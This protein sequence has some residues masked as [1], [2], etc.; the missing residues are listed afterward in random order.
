MSLRNLIAG[1]GELAVRDAS[2]A[3]AL[4]LLRSADT[5]IKVLDDV[6]SG[7]RVVKSDAGFLLVEGESVE[8]V[9]NLLRSADLEGL[10]RLT[11]RDIPILESDVIEFRRLVP[12]NPE[13]ALNVLS[14]EII[15]SKT[16]RSYLDVSPENIESLPTNAITDLNKV[17]NNLLKRFVLNAKIPL[18]VGSVIVG[19]DWIIKA[20]RARKGCYMFTTINGKTTSCKIMAYSCMSDVIPNDECRG[21]TNYYNTTLTLMA[22]VDLEDS[23]GRKT[24]LAAAVGIPV[25]Q[26]R[27]NLSK[28]VRENFTE[29]TNYIKNMPNRPTLDVCGLKNSQI[30]QGVVPPCRLC[31]PSALPTST[32]YISSAQFGENIT[33]KCINSVSIL[34]VITDAIVST[35]INLWDG[36]GTPIFN[37]LKKIGI[38][39]GSILLVVF[40]FAFA[41]RMF[42]NKSY[43]YKKI[44]NN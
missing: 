32:Q 29:A 39:L 42:M 20:S 10:V 19:A 17:S 12:D 14:R 7:L 41:V 30:E 3:E 2:E 33:F 37:T 40:I 8:S 15:E 22:I 43:S 1:L 13:K 27:A 38:I 24:N 28:I 31:S 5:S 34:D 44:K 18:I 4:Q 21:F 26:L 6:L 11:S 23:D 35:G 25:D 36:V 9:R 16:T